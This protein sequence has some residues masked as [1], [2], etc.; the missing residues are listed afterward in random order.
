MRKVI[1][2]SLVAAETKTRE[3]L[4]ALFEVLRSTAEYIEPPVLREAFELYETRLKEYAELELE[5][6]S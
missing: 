4:D 2:P 1:D 6:E 5:L 3:S